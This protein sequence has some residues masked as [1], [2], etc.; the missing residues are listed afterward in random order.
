MS[1]VHDFVAKCLAE[2]P[3]GAEKPLLGALIKKLLPLHNKEEQFEVFDEDGVYLG[4]FD[5][6]WDD[7]EMLASCPEML[8]V[9]RRQEAG[10]PVES[11]MSLEEFYAWVKSENEKDERQLAEEARRAEKS[12]HMH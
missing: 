8:E 10:L 11:A 4:Y 12:A 7:S 5:P 6:A 3:P 1:A 2:C 9:I